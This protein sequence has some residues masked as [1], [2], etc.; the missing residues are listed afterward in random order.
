MSTEESLF[1]KN[2]YNIVVASPVDYEEL[3]VEIF[4]NGRDIALVQKEKGPDKVQV[5]IFGKA[6]VPYDLLLE[7]LQA[8]KEELLR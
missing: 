5:E 2:G 4:I 3:V 8:A 7:A 6:K 1:D